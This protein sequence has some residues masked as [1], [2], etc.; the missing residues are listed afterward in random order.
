LAQQTSFH[1]YEPGW[2]EVSQS[3]KQLRVTSQRTNQQAMVS[4]KLVGKIK[5]A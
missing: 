2:N 5:M 4:K 1:L 3:K